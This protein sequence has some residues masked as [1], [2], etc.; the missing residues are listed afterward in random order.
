VLISTL[1]AFVLVAGLV[2]VTP[3]PDM[4]LVTRNVLV[5]GRQAAL[6]TALGIEAGLLVWTGASLLGIAA[7]LAASALAFTAV[8][9]AGA[10]YLVFLGIRTLLSL[11]GPREARHQQA[12]IPGTR[13]RLPA[14][15]AFQQGLL[16]NLLNPKI[17]VFF[18]SLI[19]QFVT[20]GPTATLRSML[21]AGIFMVMGLAW[22]TSYAVFADT[23]RSL[24]QRRPV[25]R[26]LDAVSGMVLVGLGVRL[27]VET[28]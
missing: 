18:T 9:L 23:A 13:S 3:G 15:L 20:P 7:L 6:L 19:P 2:I 27:A 14:G 25:K 4:A 5:H 22:L 24:L 16:S 11:R 17:A 12:V 1:V 8:K 21:L 28:R 10:A 26:L